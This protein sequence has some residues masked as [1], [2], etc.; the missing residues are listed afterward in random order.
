MRCSSLVDWPVYPRL[1]THHEGV[2]A[3]AQ[4]RADATVALGGS[5]AAELAWRYAEPSKDDTGEGERRNDRQRVKAVVQDLGVPDVSVVEHERQQPE[6][7]RARAFQCPPSAL[8]LAQVR[9]H[10]VVPAGC[11]CSRCRPRTEPPN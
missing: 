2:K 8:P 1:R 5:R 9:A 11:G 4:C 10:G 7:G 3:R 6:E